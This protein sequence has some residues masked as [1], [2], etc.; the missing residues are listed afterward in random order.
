MIKIWRL[1][2]K[3]E[4]LDSHLSL[5]TPLHNNPDF[6]LGMNDGLI[7]LRDKGIHVIGD[8]MEN[9]RLMTFEQY[10]AKY[11]LNKKIFLTYQQICSFITKNLRVY[12]GGLCISPMEEQL[13]KFT[14]S[15]SASKIFHSILI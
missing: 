12:S 2:C 14:S 13:N 3:I 9:K 5:L 1:V 4:G 7:H 10:T 11:D 8:L 15:Q 6:P